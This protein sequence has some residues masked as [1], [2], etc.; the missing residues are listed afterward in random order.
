LTGLTACKSGIEITVENPSEF[1]R[2]EMVELSVSDLPK[3]AAG[4]AYIVRTAQGDKLP[5]QLTYDDKL[6]FQTS[7]KPNEAVSY[8]IGTGAAEEYPAKVYG[9]FVPERLED[10]AWE[11]DRVAFRIYG[12][13][14][15]TKDGP[16]NGLDLWYK[17]TSDL[18]IDKWYKADI[19][20]EHSYHK[21]N[22]E[23]MDGYN[24]GRSLGGGAMAPFVGDS[25]ILNDNFVR[26]ETLENGPLRTTFRLF[27]NDLKI[28]SL[29]TVS[30]TRTISLDA[31]S[32][33]TRI[34]QEYGVK[35]SL[36]VAAGI[37]K[38]AA[39]DEA[40]SA[41]TE[42][43]T[44]AVV[45]QEKD[46]PDSTNVFVGMVF[47]QGLE[48][49]ISN[50][51]TIFHP[52]KLV[53]QTHY[54]VLGITTYYPGHPVTYYTGYGWEKYGFASLS[55]FQNY[56]GYFSKAIEEPLIINYQK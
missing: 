40:Y 51:Y 11:N 44:A 42:N 27:Y 54:H 5:S 10:Y 12:H 32:Q 31:G 25:L 13:A 33:L 6:I 8:T 2:S 46:N 34:T 23:G 15:I 18:V 45:Y 3:L 53:W 22:G 24:V 30:E 16:S 4:K 20:G 55:D 39:D 19:A 36:I 52:K 56:I 49:V 28:D 29:R 35:D 14:L 47:P 37:V 26:Y 48:N 41:Y 17:R 50:R 9:R 43:G 38:R 7:L 21:D 1:E